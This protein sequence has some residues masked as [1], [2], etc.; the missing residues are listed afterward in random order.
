A[1]QAGVQHVVIPAVAPSNFQAVRDLAHQYPCGAYALGI[2]PLCIPAASHQDLIVL[3]QAICRSMDDPK[4]V[5]VGEIGQDF[6]IPELKA[7]AMQRKQESFYEAQLKLAETYQLPVILHVRRSQDRIL[8]YLRMR[9]GAY[10]IAHAVNGS[11]QQAE[12]FIELGFALGAG[13]AMTFARARQ[14]RR[15]ATELDLEHWVL[16]TDAP[17]I[18]PAWLSAQHGATPRNE[19]AEIARIADVLAQL[20]EVSRDDVLQVT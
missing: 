2:H 17:D 9:K 5:A 19:P 3:E 14:V 13:G 1:V 10:G 8:K 11:Y 12:A 4:F 16:E 7:P 15:L 20:R 6:F 18:P